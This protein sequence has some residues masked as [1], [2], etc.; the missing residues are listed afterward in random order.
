MYG[1]SEYLMLWHEVERARLY[2]QAVEADKRLPPTEKP[3]S[4]KAIHPVDSVEEVKDPRRIPTDVN[5][6]PSPSP[7][8]TRQRSNHYEQSQ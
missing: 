8:I 2:R 5:G 6:P 1:M 3:L 4:R 7:P